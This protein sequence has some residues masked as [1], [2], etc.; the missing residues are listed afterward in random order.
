[1]TR[2]D[3]V[4]LIN[5]KKS[6]LCVGLDTDSDKLPTHLKGDA[7]GLLKFNLEI[8]QSTLPY[9][10]AYKLN[11]AFYE[12]MGVKGW[13]VL[14]NT[15]AAIPSGEAMIIA[16]AKRGDIGNTAAQYANAFYHTFKCDAVTVNP[17]M[18][19]DSVRPFLQDEGKWAIVLGLTSNKGAADIELL[20][21]NDG[22]YVFEA[23]MERIVKWGTP[24]NL[25]FVVGATKPA[26]FELVR[27][28]APEHFLL[29]PGVGAQGGELKDLK[30]LI[31][32]DVGILVNS[33][34]NIIYASNGEN[35]AEA[36]GLEAS[37]LQRD[38]AAMLTL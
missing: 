28:I 24:D 21:T 37:Q 13:E 1:M 3:L 30:S 12:A 9:A 22:K 15:I 16:D 38:M 14:Q 17:Y 35:F 6:F 2:K 20:K 29:I 32:K 26:F 19:E 11:I 18:G 10:V 8:I 25:M 36:A 34:R 4:E 5:K 33:S 23:A 7:D 31:T 27:R